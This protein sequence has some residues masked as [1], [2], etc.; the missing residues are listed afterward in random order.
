M[1]HASTQSMG[2]ASLKK[3]VKEC[4]TVKT[5]CICQNVRTLTPAKK[6]THNHVKNLLLEAVGFI[7]TVRIVIKILQQAKKDVNIQK[8]L[9]C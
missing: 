2:I 4:I 5:A 9:R 6:N 3:P 8:R 1:S 7:V